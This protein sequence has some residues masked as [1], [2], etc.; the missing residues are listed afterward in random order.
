MN[1]FNLIIRYSGLVV[2]ALFLSQC[3]PKNLISDRND[4]HLMNEFNKFEYEYSLHEGIKFKLLG[5][6]N[7]AVYFLKKC[8]EIFPFSDVAH[9]ELSK[10]YYL[11]GRINEAVDHAVMSTEIAPEN[12]WYHYHLGGLFHEAGAIEKAIGVY[13]KAIVI[14][15][16]KHDLYFTLAAMYFSESKFDEA[17]KTYN[18]VETLTGIDERV[19]LPREQIY[20]IKGEYEKAHN[21]IVKLIDKFPGEA[22]YL[23]VL[24]ELYAS[25]E[26]YEEALDTYRK[27]FMIEPD[28]GIAQLSV[29]EFYLRQGNLDMTY[30]YLI[31][32][33]R[34]TRLDYTEKIQAYSALTQDRMIQQEFYDNIEQLGYL[35]LD[36]Y[37]ENE[38]T[39]AV[40]SD[41]FIFTGNYDKAILFLEELYTNDT[42]NKLFAEQYISVL[43]FNDDHERVLE[44]GGKMIISFPESIPINYFLGIAC[45][46]TGKDE[47]AIEVFEQILTLEGINNEINVQVLSNLGD[48]YNRRKDYKSSD[49]YF[50]KALEIDANN[51]IALNNFAYYLALRGEKLETAHDYSLKTIEIHPDNASFL[52]TYAWILYKKGDFRKALKYIELAYKNGGKESYEIIMHYVEI[53]SS[54]ERFNEALEFLDKARGLTTDTLEVD[55]TISRIKSLIPQ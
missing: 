29:A 17:L 7:K 39:K 12:L 30:S 41:F 21:E 13:E 45:F 18:L 2:L 26:M 40:M 11:A 1:V 49:H 42:L 44:V 5:E 38:F 50:Q 6:Y 46:M 53:L 33:F 8:I 48:L 15:P 14:F 37:P 31:N 54:L 16:D 52:D 25:M 34:N 32:A 47:C 10:I 20:I 3:R 55:E 28:N 23:G 35:L 24:A 22:K 36:E 51:V 43:S 9:Y 4:F 27:L 19:Y